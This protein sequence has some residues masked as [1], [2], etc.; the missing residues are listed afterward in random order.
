MNTLILFNT[1]NFPIGDSEEFNS[2]DKVRNAVISITARD[3]FTSKTINSEVYIQNPIKDFKIYINPSDPIVFNSDQS[4]KEIQFFIELD[5]NVTD[6]FFLVNFD[7]DSEINF[8]QEIIN[9]SSSFN[10]F[11]KLSGIYKVNVT[12]F[13]KVSS[14]SK[15]IQIEILEDFSN[16][17]CIPT[18]RLFPF[19][20]SDDYNITKIGEFYLA[21]KE[22]DIRF[23]CRWS[24]KNQFILKLIV[25]K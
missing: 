11:F 12:L 1:T 19:S 23:K 24:N 25:D 9:G 16:F 5:S 10:H 6:P 3:R 15:I 7:D 2:G 14:H 22:Y 21:R 17:D 8:E 13:N 20:F 18:W 4:G